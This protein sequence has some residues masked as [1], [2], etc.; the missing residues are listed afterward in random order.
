VALDFLVLPLSF[1]VVNF[2]AIMKLSPIP[3]TGIVIQK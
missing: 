1:E 3:V 2:T